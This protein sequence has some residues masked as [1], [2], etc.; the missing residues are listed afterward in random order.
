[1][2]AGPDPRDRHSRPRGTETFADLA[3][4]D[5][6]GLRVAWTTDLG[7]WARADENVGRAVE[8]AAR[9]FEA[10]GARVENATPFREDPTDAYLAIV[11]LDFDVFAMRKLVARQPDCVNPRL[12]ELI[13]H[14]WTFEEV[15]KAFATRRALYNQVW[16]F[17][18]SHDLLLTPTT[19]TA[20]FDVGLPGPR[21]V[22]GV[23][24]T[25]EQPAP[26]FTR[27][28]NLTGSPAASIPAAWTEDGLPIGLQIVGTHLADHLVLRGV[29]FE[30]AAPWLDRRPPVCTE[31]T[32]AWSRL[33]AAAG[34]RC[35]AC[36]WNLRPPLPAQAG[37]RYGSATAEGRLGLMRRQQARGRSSA[38]VI[39]VRR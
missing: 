6:S 30:Q 25:A 17:F 22:A 5:V 23:P 9:R 26:S 1:M 8:A 12:A 36:P 29:T 10:L 7:G 18:E 15:T 32:F 11:A 39:R 19:P 31:L 4:T 28:F 2:I 14:E 27:P 24:V 38:S 16:R 20:A 33:S 13:A 37:R 34:V 35:L 3:D 21:A